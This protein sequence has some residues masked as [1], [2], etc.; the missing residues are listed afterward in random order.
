MDDQNLSIRERKSAKL[1]LLIL[2][3]TQAALKTTNFSDIHVKEIC[4][5]V[6]ISKVTFFRY[7]HQKE[8]VLLYLLRIWAFKT[9]VSIQKQ[10]LTGLKAVHYIFDQFADLCEKHPS[11]MLHLIKYYAVTDIVL[12]PISIKKAEKIL[13]FPEMEK[14]AEFEILAF[15]KL[16]EKHLL[17]GIFNTEITK[18]SN[19]EDMVSMLLTT[20]YGSIIVSKMRQFPLKSLLKKNISSILNSYR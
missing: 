18:S 14:I 6:D 8:D 12:K 19:V 15:D 10:Q 11:M 5:E 1:K 7:F 4:K 16:L 3:T 9:S 2:S 13:L 17:E 20:V